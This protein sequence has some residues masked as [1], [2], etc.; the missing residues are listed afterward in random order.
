M[1]FDRSGFKERGP[2][3]LASEELI[4]MAAAG[5]FLRVEELL[6]SGIVH[7]DV[8]DKDGHTALIGAT[9]TILN[10]KF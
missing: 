8:A 1:K 2:L 9:V 4:K 7:P 3:E 5:N 10:I 6:N